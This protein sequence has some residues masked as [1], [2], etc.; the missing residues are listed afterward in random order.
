MSWADEGLSIPCI[1]VVWPVDGSF[2]V[3]DLA[4]GNRTVFE[5]PNYDDARMWSLEEEYVRVGRKELDEE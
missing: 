4:Q 5:S 1:V 3:V 2:Q